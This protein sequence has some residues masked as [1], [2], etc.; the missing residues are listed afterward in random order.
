MRLLGIVVICGVAF[1]TVSCAQWAGA[2]MPAQQQPSSAFTSDPS[3]YTLQTQPTAP[4]PPMPPPNLGQYYSP[5]P[6][7]S[8]SGAQT[9]ELGQVGPYGNG[10]IGPYGNGAIGAYGSSGRGAYGGVCV[11]ASC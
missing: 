11:G 2:T 4:P 7:S 3:L 8:L 6:P 5:S 1:S 10:A 9:F